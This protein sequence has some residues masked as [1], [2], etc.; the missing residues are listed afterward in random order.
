MILQPAAS[1]AHLT[2][3]SLVSAAAI[4]SPSQSAFFTTI[5]ASPNQ[6]SSMDFLRSHYRGEEAFVN[7]TLMEIWCP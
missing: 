1:D 5:Y 3:A 4:T 2:H 7:K 6:S